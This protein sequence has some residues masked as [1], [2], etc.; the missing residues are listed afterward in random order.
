MCGYVHVCS[1]GGGGGGGV[2]LVVLVVVSA[3]WAGEG[4]Q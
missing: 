2:T 1:R 4:P 3:R